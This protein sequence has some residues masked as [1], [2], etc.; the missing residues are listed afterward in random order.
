MLFK[1]HSFHTK[2]PSLKRHNMAY[3]VSFFNKEVKS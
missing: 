2:K 1:C 3:T